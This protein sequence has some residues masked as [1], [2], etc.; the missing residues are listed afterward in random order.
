MNFGNILAQLRKSRNTT[1]EELAAQL[2][3]TAAAVSKWENGYTLP[4]ILM[5]CAIADY[6]GVTTDHLLG[7]DKE[8]KYAVIAAET[9]ELGQQIEEIASKHGLTA[10]GIYTSFAEADAAAQEMEGVDYILAGFFSGTYGSDSVR[11]TFVS[12]S[13]KTEEILNGM[14]MAL[15]KF[16]K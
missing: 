10:K 15:Q 6:F 11:S 4:D 3:V 16:L 13:Q 5:L 12:V 14:D 8:Q 2:G 7:R 9:Q 1:Q